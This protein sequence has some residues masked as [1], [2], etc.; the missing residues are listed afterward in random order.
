MHSIR[1]FSAVAGIVGAASILGAC[2]LGG[3]A[4][5]PPGGFITV[6]ANKSGTTVS[7]TASAYFIARLDT[8]NGS[9]LSSY[10]QSMIPALGDD[11]CE[12]IDTTATPVE[13]PMP[14]GLD[15][16]SE[17]VLDTG[18]ASEAITM[19]PAWSEGY[20]T[21]DV[22]NTAE[23]K[24]YS[25]NLEGTSEVPATSWASALSMPGLFE[26][27]NFS[28]GTLAID[29]DAGKDISWDSTG[30]DALLLTFQ[31]DTRNGRCVVKDDGSFKIP[32]QFAED[33][34]VSGYFSI[35]AIKQSTQ[36]L[37]GREVLLAGTSSQSGYFTVTGGTTNPP[38][39][40]CTIAW[41][42][43][44]TTTGKI[45]A[46]LLDLPVAS[47][48]SGTGSFD[49]STRIGA[50]LYDYASGSA[51]DQAIAPSGT[52]DLSVA[53][54]N[55]DDS[56]DFFDSTSQSYTANSGL[57]V[58]GGTGSFLG[59]ITDPS[60]TSPVPGEGV[61]AMMYNGVSLSLGD[62]GSY[63]QCY[64]AAAFGPMTPAQRLARLLA[65]TK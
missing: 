7:G 36:M 56:V 16:G 11:E 33:L 24:T 29:A 63:S 65:A 1:K 34:G 61:I 60:S 42:S 31:G 8:S 53:G 30:A 35:T 54:Y 47:W 41:I 19:T 52:F 57:T 10:D 45:H 21:G 18:S 5:G 4:G 44:G 22:P 2:D 6:S 9:Q 55:T 48:V 37:N 3:D 28:T 62:N 58:S 23:G 15:V 46:Y 64:D 51:V 50:L 20:Y 49:G 14:V 40:N 39:T 43:P 13:T 27:N 25:I 26:L 17:V 12:L 32:A 38:V 59:K